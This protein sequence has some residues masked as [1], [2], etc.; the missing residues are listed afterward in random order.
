MHDLR[1]YDPSFLISIRLQRMEVIYEQAEG[2]VDSP[3]RHDYYTV[4]WSQADSGSHIIDFNEYPLAQNAVF[5]VSPGQIHQVVTHSKPKGWVITFSKAFLQHNHISEAFIERINL[6]NSFEERPPLFLADAT[7]NKMQVLFEMM[8]RDFES[9][10]ELKIGLL[11]AYLKIFLIHCVN[12]CDNEE[13]SL[14]N[15][16]GGKTILKNFKALVKENYWK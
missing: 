8:E 4:I 9:P 14:R 2:Q 11:S 15:D 3:H 10:N 5:F 1:H 6:F 16:H 13:I 7:A 12:A